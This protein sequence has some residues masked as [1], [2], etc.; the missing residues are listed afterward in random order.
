M[1]ISSL[2]FIQSFIKLLPCARHSVNYCECQD[3]WNVSLPEVLLV[4]R[5]DGLWADDSSPVLLNSGGSAGA[6]ES[7]GKEVFTSVLQGE[8]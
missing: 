2:P 4:G 5:E 7:S 6:C 3:E 8:Y 1:N